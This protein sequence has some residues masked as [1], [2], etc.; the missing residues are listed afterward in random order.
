[1]SCRDWSWTRGYIGTAVALAA[2]GAST[3]SLRAEWPEWIRNVETGGRWH[4]AIF[5]TVPT[6]SGAVEV[7]RSP[8]D[9]HEALTR[10]AAVTSDLQ[11]LALRA[12]AAEETLDAT[13]AETDWKAYASASPD[14]AAGQLALADFYHRRLMPQK[15]ADALA[16]AAR[17]ED[18]PADRLLPVSERRSW[19]TFER[20]FALVDA[21]QLPDAFAELQARAW[22]ARYPQQTAPYDRLFRFLI[23]RNRTA[24]AEVLLAS[25]QKAFPSSEA[26]VLKSRAELA[27]RRGATADA[28]DVYDRAFRPLWDAATIQEYFALLERTHRLRAFLDR[29]R[30]D[31]AAHPADLTPVAR[32]FYYYHRAGNVGAAEYAL[33]EFEARREKMPRTAE[34]LFTL[35]GLYEQ[36]RN[37]NEAI[38]YYASIYSLPGAS[39]TDVEQALV[40][41]IDTLLRAPE[42]PLRFG[43]SDLSFYRDIATLDR[44]P[45][46][47]NGVLSL[48]FNSVSPSQQYAQ[49]EASAT[50]YFHRTRAT[51]LVRLLETRFPKSA[52]RARLNAALVS[53]YAAYGASDAV[54]ESGRRFLTTF[55]DAADRTAVTLTMADAFARKDQVVDEFAA[56]DRLLQEL[57]GRAD[58]VPLGAGTAYPGFDSKSRPTGARSQEYARVLDRYIAR[59]VSRGQTADALGVY[60]R[61][62][63]RNPNDPGLYAATAQFLE[64]NNVAADVEQVYRLAIKQFPDP[65]W[66]HRLA[67][68]Y[69]RRKQAAAFEELTRQVTRTFEGTEL[70]RYFESV[71]HA[72]GPVGPHLYLQ[73]NV[74]AHQRFPHHLVFVRNLLSAYTTRGTNDRAAWEALLRRH[75]FEDETLANVFFAELSRTNRLDAEIAGMRSVAN[76]AV[77]A[78]WVSLAKGHPIAARFLAEADIWRSRFES[79]TPILSALAAEFPSDVELNQRAGSLHRSLSHADARETDAAAQVL[80]RLQQYDPRSAAHLTT[81]GEIH[82]DRERYD[83]ARGHWNRIPDIEPGRP[84]GY[85]DAATIFWDY[86][87]F[88]DAL[89][90]IAQGRTKLR[91]PTLYAYEAGAIYEGLRQP[92]P[93]VEEYTRGALSA[94]GASPAWSRLTRLAKRPAYRELVEST[95]ADAVEGT[96]PGGAAIS[97]RIAV[98]EAQDRREDIER[99]L[100]ALLDRTSSLQLMTEVGSHGQ[101]L[102]FESV[103]TRALARQIESMTDP[104]EKLQLRY[105]LVRL[106]ESRGELALARQAVE[107]LYAEHPRTL[108]IVRQTADF[109]WRHDHRREAIAVLTRAASQAYPA[110][111]RQFTFE[112]ALKSTVAG[113]YAAA[114]E[115][116]QRLLTDDPFNADYLAAVAD[117]HARAGDDQALRD[118]YASRIDAMRSVTMAAEERT[119]RNAGQRRALIPALRR[120]NDHVG[121]IDQYIEIINRYPDD[122]A[123][124]NEAGAY[125]REHSRTAQLLAYYPKTPAG[126]PRDY[127]WPMLL[128][129]LHTQVEDYPAAIAA[130]ATAAA[131]RPDRPDFQIARGHLE[132]RLMRFDDAIAS[133]AK[134][135]ELTY[136]DPQWMEKVAGLH[137]RQGRAADASKALHSALVEG[138]P[139]RP[140]LFFTA[141]KRLELW[142]MPDAAKPFV[143]DGVRMAKPSELLE[144]GSAYVSVY[145]MLRQAPAVLDRLLAAR[146]AASPDLPSPENALSVR[147]NELGDVV[148]RLY[149]PEEKVAFAAS[150]E[151][152]KATVPQNDFVQA[153]VPLAER[154]GLLELAVRWRTELMI[155]N[156]Q[157]EPNEHLARLVDLQTRRLRF[158]ELATELERFAD[159]GARSGFTARHYAADAYRKGGDGDGEFRVLSK[160]PLRTLGDAHRQRYFALLLDRD[161]QRLIALAAAETSSI[162]DAAANFLVAHGTF[163]QALAAVR[164]R[165]QGLPPIWTTAYTALIG[166]HFSRFDVATT[167]AFNSALGA[168]TVS[169]RLEPVDRSLQLAGDTWFAYASRFGEFLTFGKRSG[170][171]SYLPATVERTP[172]RS[173]AYVGLADFYRDTGDGPSALAEYD[174]AA[175]LNPERSDVHL[176]AAAILWRQGRRSDAIER[177]KQAM[178]LLADHAARAAVDTEPLVAVL[179][180]IGVR[181]LLP[182]LREPADKMVRAYIAR[183]GT[184]RADALL[185]AAF[186]ATND[187]ASGTDWLI[188]V[189]RAAPN[190]VDTLG[191]IAR[192]TWL[193]DA[194]RDRVY[195][196]T[197]IVLEAAVKRE[198]GVARTAKEAE[199]DTWRVARIRSLVE[200]KQSVR[201][202]ELLRALP[203]DVRREHYQTDV[204]ELD[205]RIAAAQGTLEAALESHDRQTVRT[206]NADA[207]QRAA[208]ALRQAGD[209]ASAR[210]IMEFVY[211][212]QLDRGE[213]AP[214]VFLGLAEIRVQQGNLP[215]ALALL[216]R[217]TL[218][219]GERFE[220]LASSADLFE[221][222]NRPSEALEFRRARVKAVPWDAGSQLALARTEI[223]AAENREAALERLGRVAESPTEPYA[224]RVQAALTFASGGG[225]R[226]LPPQTEIDRLLALPDLTPVAASGPMFVAARV[227]A[228]ERADDA[229]ARSALL[230]EAVAI[231]P[232][233]VSLRAPLFG[234]LMAAGR[235]AEAIEA[236]A[237]LLARDA[238]LATPGPAAAPR[239]RLARAIGEAYQ[240]IDRLPDAVRLLRLAHELTVALGSRPEA[241][242]I[243]QRIAAIN[244]EIERRTQNA[245]R[246]PY[247]GESLDQ[248]QLVRPR[249]L[250]R[251]AAQRGVR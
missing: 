167:A 128:A 53:T 11:L 130:Y 21:H 54:I 50:A 143:D 188:D 197:V 228:A 37:H 127:R 38:R 41:I 205:V 100:L 217:L 68:W 108:G 29:A 180:S 84:A 60:R 115:M 194:V 82:A 158:A 44:G 87:Q 178:G 88:D 156:R 210:R 113:D 79:A 46:F 214:P 34:E 157:T 61:E 213:L 152:R 7:R 85:L 184:Y 173:E 200:T 94:A 125:A 166:L 146:R 203:E 208:T 136:H 62:I 116:L 131:I 207:L 20:L 124:L 248:P 121:A 55:P 148:D 201:A 250:A 91:N 150:L 18:T 175:V 30:T 109:Y 233:D 19:K 42:Q 159:T 149:S 142:G 23:D 72:G 90:I 40:R 132:E 8:A 204:L 220:Q 226:G 112:A 216:R 111:S 105:A 141:A 17:A 229:A 172:A 45:G 176:R 174:R 2:I 43:N 66:H 160:I 232:D 237:P 14:P 202:A 13:A 86:Y 97:L 161:P 185:R 239:A 230:R 145:T 140:A 169:D 93:A 36:T 104:I 206:L 120:L 135:Y 71:V 170:A 74:Y 16:A 221:R 9:A 165:G 183:N 58:R 5:R 181:K 177:W 80:A 119:R 182:E 245:A 114:R 162:R 222:L 187:P 153:L 15:E 133:F 81:L 33:A 190:Q 95:S 192:A 96:A 3:Y 247:L 12:R 219:V 234:A 164:A 57:G 75:W 56:Y 139:P 64:Q 126:S 77:E 70:A 89:R 211:V 243:Q 26:W 4:D 110:L 189:A 39:A 73:L 78:N 31:V 102:G 101:R 99:F 67:R 27:T 242:E 144:E 163:D 223:A 48:V 147:L 6:P 215:A 69:L 227:A 168:A 224:L 22:L 225:R 98:L 246:R 32:V 193:P 198:H 218:V 52:H 59:L 138:R 195:E 122:D 238:S 51:D 35:A 199:A 83:S 118:F 251:A 196:R 10:A 76:A 123:L 244:A 24:D 236:I 179:E 191:T 65:S 103:R 25:Y 154:A 47:L 129:K 1:M 137:A 49:Q 235:P 63:E 231:R 155:T 151:S 92:K 106:Y 240:R 134:T 212:R 249:I 241:A 171:A 107:T 28:L 186:L 117:T 209:E